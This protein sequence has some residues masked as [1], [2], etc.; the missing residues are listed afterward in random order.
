MKKIL[1]G[2]CL[3]MVT[4]TA[5]K[6]ETDVLTKQDTFDGK[7]DLVRTTG[8]I[9]G[10][11]IVTDWNMLEFDGKSVYFYTANE[12]K[13]DGAFITIDE[14]KKTISLDFPTDAGFTIDLRNDLIKNYVFEGDSILY[15]NSDCCDRVNYE[16]RK[17][18]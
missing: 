9:T 15:L 5:C 3:A 7:W 1:I 8:T 12:V 13:Q 16:L 17:K 18:Q 6:K 4:I 11:G 14:T 2:L 10:N